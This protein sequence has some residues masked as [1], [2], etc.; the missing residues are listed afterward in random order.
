MLVIPLLEYRHI[1]DIYLPLDFKGFDFSVVFNDFK[2]RPETK[3]K[4]LS[5]FIKHIKDEGDNIE[6]KK[7]LF[8]IKLVEILQKTVLQ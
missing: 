8:A 7:A 5:R 6:N 1:N 3:N 2:M 4:S